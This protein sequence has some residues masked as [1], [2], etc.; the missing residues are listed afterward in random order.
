[1][2]CK[3]GRAVFEGEADPGSFWQLASAEGSERTPAYVRHGPA[4]R[5]PPQEQ[6]PHQVE[7]GTIL[8]AVWYVNHMIFFLHSFVF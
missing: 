1:M 7:Q 6:L 5:P 8:Q 2:A 4:L 3:E